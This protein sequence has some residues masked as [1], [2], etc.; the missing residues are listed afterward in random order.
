[1]RLHSETQPAVLTRSHSCVTQLQHPAG[2]GGLNGG[3]SYALR[4]HVLPV[5]LMSQR[6]HDVCS[7]SGCDVCDVAYVWVGSLGRSPGCLLVTTSGRAQMK[8]LVRDK[9][10]VCYNKV[11]N[12]VGWQVVVVA[13]VEVTG[14]P[15][16]VMVKMSRY[17]A[18]ATSPVRPGQSVGPGWTVMC[19]CLAD[20][21]IHPY[22]FPVSAPLAFTVILEACWAIHVMRPR[23]AWT[24][25]PCV[26]RGPSC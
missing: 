26:V 5:R 19:P 2:L 6:P 16:V 12:I 21:M 15:V 9:G 20:V 10:A 1:M 14:R 4:W 17:V 11:G 13:L 25:W 22:A 18:Q 7:P 8:A 23:A 3:L 24:S